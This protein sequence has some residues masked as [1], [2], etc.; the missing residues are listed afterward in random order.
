MFC[1]AWVM[2]YCLTLVA[3]YFIKYPPSDVPFFVFLNSK[4]DVY[5]PTQFSPT[6]GLEAIKPAGLMIPRTI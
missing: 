2:I 3:K 1:T 4:H 6:R 5:Y